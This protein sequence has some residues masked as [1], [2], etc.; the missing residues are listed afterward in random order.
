MDISSASQDYYVLRYRAG[1]DRWSRRIET[2]ATSRA[3]E[4]IVRK[5]A[6]ERPVLNMLD[7][8]CG[9]MPLTLPLVQRHG[10]VQIVG[11]DWA[12]GDIL[13]AYPD[14]QLE[15]IAAPRVTAIVSD[16]FSFQWTHRFDVIADLGLFHHLSPDDWRRY[17][18]KIVELLREDGH[19]CL[20]VFH[21]EDK[22]WSSPSPG[23]H[24]RK[25]YYCHYHNLDSIRSIFGSR[26]DQVLEVGRYQHWEHVVAFYHMTRTAPPVM[27]T[28]RES[29]L[30]SRSPTR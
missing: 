29:G 15:L 27:A 12:L 14:F 7:I 30:P 16:L 28:P 20:E 25:G 5:L 9:R 18:D 13:Q 19:F 24:A 6:G 8:G 23:G 4:V 3:L 10:N 11:I 1:E 26:F 2:E 22:N 17:S 21:P